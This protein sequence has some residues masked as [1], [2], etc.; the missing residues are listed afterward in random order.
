M[1]DPSQVRVHDCLHDF[2]PYRTP[3]CAKCDAVKEIFRAYYLERKAKVPRN[4]EQ[5]AGDDK[6]KLSSPKPFPPGEGDGGGIGG[7][8]KDLG[9][10]TAPLTEPQNG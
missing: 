5:V 7:G 9:T 2:C 1:I 8:E 4:E 6:G 3:E 10:I